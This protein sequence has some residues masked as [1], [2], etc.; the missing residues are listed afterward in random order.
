MILIIYD[1]YIKLVK[2]ISQEARTMVY[3]GT[4]GVEKII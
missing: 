2:V 3:L 1:K 4:K